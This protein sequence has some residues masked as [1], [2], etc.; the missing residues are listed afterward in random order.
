MASV[1]I[2]VNNKPFSIACEEG[3]EQRVR[4][5]SAYIDQRVSDIASAGAASNESQLMVLT[6]LVLTDEIFE[7][8]HELAALKAQIASGSDAEQDAEKIR[9]ELQEQMNSEIQQRN[10]D[11]AYSIF[12]I[13]EDIETLSKRL[14]SI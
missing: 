8:Q 4:D 5:L 3:Q 2:T 7:M 9:E 14:Q 1:T 12:E 13:A 10:A 6:S 11:L